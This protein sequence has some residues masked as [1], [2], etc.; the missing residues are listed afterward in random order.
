MLDTWIVLIGA[1]CA[2]SCAIP[3]V[4]LVLRRMSLMGDA[5]S[6]TVLPGIAIAFLITGSRDPVAMLIGAVVIGLLTAFLVETIQSIGRVEAGASMGIVFTFLFA[7]GLVLMRQAVD[8]V[9]IDP[10][11]V[12]YGSIEL[13]WFDQLR[14]AGMNV[15]RGIVVNGVMLLLN[16]FLVLLFYKEF[17][18]TSFDPSLAQAQGIRPSIMHYLLMTMTAT[19]AVAAFETVGSILVVAMFIVPAATA[20]V[21][22]DRY[23][24]LL[25]L[26]IAI[27]IFSAVLGHLG[28]IAIPIWFGFSGT[29]T[30]G[31]MAVASG[32]LFILAW[33]GSPKYGLCTRGLRRIE[34]RLRI[35]RE[36]VLGVLWRLEERKQE[37]AKLSQLAMAIG[38]HP[39]MMRI[40]LSHLLQQGRISKDGSGWLLTEKGR[41][42]ATSI[43]RTHRLWEVYL[44]KHFPQDEHQLHHA[45]SRLEHVTSESM[46]SALGDARTDPHG[47]NVPQNDDP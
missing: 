33:F 24:F 11:C 34:L 39:M 40:A 31:A 25:C 42:F 18:I 7:F 45:A 32:L 12:L 9:D 37:A 36:D 5:I 28:A 38:A 6:H 46:Q 43:I 4:L 27:A 1:T 16:L 17:K 20:Y 44:D 23:G 19:T 22:T 10:D 41:L 13:A 2:I 47:S 21:L 8:H 15:P 14:I 29:S 35:L 3:G 26:S 30:A